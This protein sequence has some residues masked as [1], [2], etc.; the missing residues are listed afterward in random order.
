MLLDIFNNDAFS[1][2][3]LTDA[4]REVKH[5]PSYVSRRGLFTTTSVDTLS[6]AIERDKNQN[7]MIVPSSPRGA[8]GATFGKN[9]RSMLNLTV[10]HFQVD[11]AIYAD[12]VQG[13]RAFGQERAVEILQAK[14]ADRAAEA[15][16]FFGLTEE[17]HRLKVLT[18]GKLYDSDGVTVLADFL[19]LF[20][21]SLPA[22]LDFSFDTNVNGKLRQFCTEVHRQMAAILDGLPFTSIEFICGDKFFDDLVANAEVRAAYEGHGAALQLL[23]AYISGSGQNATFGEVNFGGIRFINYRGNFN[24]APAIDTDKAHGYPIGVPGLFRSVYAPADYME[25]VNTM[26]QRLYAKQ[27]RM[28]NDKGV[29]LEFQTNVLHYC[30]R[31]R[32][33]LR[34]KRT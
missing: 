5:I 23:D 7:V 15:S 30:T 8:P 3:S 31:P 14:I 29:N 26:G 27:W 10:P 21:E 32:T 19:T 4:M 11:D 20:G 16:Q 9:K 6:V 17:F 1:V 2:T 33:L 22:E 25:T 12:E 24:G 34:A 13:V 18:T 28:G